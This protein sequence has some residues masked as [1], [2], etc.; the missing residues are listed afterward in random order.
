MRIAGGRLKGRALLT[1][2]GRDIRPT[3]DRLRETIFNIL[4]HRFDDAARD[5]RVLD[6]FAGTGAM[7]IEALSRGAAFAA[8]VDDGAEARGLL[9]GNIEALGLGGVTRVLKRD[10]AE[11]GA[12]R[13][14]DPFGLVFCDPPYGKGLGEKALDSA[15][16]G[17]WLKP[18]ALVVLEERAG[19]K[20]QLPPG[21][22]VL[23]ERESGESKL[24]FS[25]VT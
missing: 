7:G 9:R 11:L 22:S 19:A 17:G 25:R 21:F 16:Q 6:L 14:F 10:A 12:I 5:A 3:S 20:L 24:V 18:D 23:D 8:F 1:P 4:A 2:A 13:S 15:L